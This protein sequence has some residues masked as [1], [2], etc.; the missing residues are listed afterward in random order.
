MTATA[1]TA[2][3]IRSTPRTRVLK[4]IENTFAVLTVSVMAA[5]AIVAG[6]FFSR[7]VSLAMHDGEFLPLLAVVGTASVLFVG[8]KIVSPAR[9]RD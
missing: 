2:D 3:T 7:A 5:V 1:D 6:Y 4:A 8:W 9:G